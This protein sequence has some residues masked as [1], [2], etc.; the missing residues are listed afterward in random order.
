MELYILDKSFNKLSIIDEYQSI[1]WIDRY[2]EPGQFE[3][4]LGADS[5]LLNYLVIGNYIVHRDS[6]HVMVIEG[7]RIETSVE[8]GNHFTIT[9]RSV[10]AF[11]GRRIIWRQTD[12]NNVYLQTAIQRLLNENLISPTLTLRKI[13]NFIFSASTDPKII[14][15][16]ITAQYT[17]DNLLEV[18]NEICLDKKLGFKVVL[19]SSNR[20]VFSLYAGTDRSYDQ[21]SETYVVFSPKFDN[22]INSNYFESDVNYKNVTLVAG[23]GEGV[24]RLTYTVGTTAGLERRELFTDARDISDKDED[25]VDIP[26][27]VYNEKLKERGKEKLAADENKKEKTFDGKVDSSQT[28]VYG[29][30]FYL[31]DVVQVRNEYGLQGAARVIEYVMSESVEGGL[32]YYPTFE[33]IQEEVEE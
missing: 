32:E 3:L 8:E 7:V 27:P 9:G 18:L 5:K 2:Y 28:F 30:D 23:A 26:L 25:N 20:F 13:P 6:E 10:E 24:D 14:S 17:G 4:Y 15:Q 16:K 12:F 22:I 21:T 11:I 1:L 29:E 33:A 19:D 31:G